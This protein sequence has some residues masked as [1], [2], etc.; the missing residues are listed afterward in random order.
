MTTYQITFNETS[1]HGKFLLD[2]INKNKDAFILEDPYEMTKE[3]FE[4]MCNEARA[5]FERGEC[6]TLDPK[7]FKK[8]LGLE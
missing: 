8:F 6:K 4:T 7:D 2:Y 5:E 3:E 1:K